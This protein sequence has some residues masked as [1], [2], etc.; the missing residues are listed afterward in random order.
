MKSRDGYVLL[1][2]QRE[3]QMT[4]LPQGAGQGSKARG[5]VGDARSRIA[6]PPCFPEAAT[7]L[8][9]EEWNWSDWLQL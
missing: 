3:K 7:G 9:T 4:R 1:E 5:Q 2:Q 6:R 8:R